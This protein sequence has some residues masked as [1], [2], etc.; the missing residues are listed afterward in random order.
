MLNI[1]SCKQ[2]LPGKVIKDWIAFHTKNQTEYSTIANR[3]LRY[4]N[5]S[6]EKMYRIVLN[7]QSTS[8]GKRKKGNPDVVNAISLAAE[9]P[10]HKEGRHPKPAKHNGAGTGEFFYGMAIPTSVLDEVAIAAKRTILD[11]SD[12]WDDA[13]G[14][15]VR[16]PNGCDVIP[17]HLGMQWCE[18]VMISPLEGMPGPAEGEWFLESFRQMTPFF[19]AYPS[20]EALIDEFRTAI[21]SYVTDLSA[22]DMHWWKSR[23]GIIQ[24]AIFAED[25]PPYRKDVFP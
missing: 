4:M 6:D 25:A 21:G 14:A 11:I 10:P 20:P 8:G 7:P 15:W 22:N 17:I 13:R 24:C 19:A 5:V 9:T 12:E 18:G 1:L 2:A 23:I 3:M 16:L